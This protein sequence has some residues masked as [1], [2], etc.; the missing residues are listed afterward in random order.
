MSM[1]D[2]SNLNLNDQT[3]NNRSL[4]FQ[5]SDGITLDIGE[6]EEDSDKD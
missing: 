2:S 5:A 4:H 3:L 1:D 6:G